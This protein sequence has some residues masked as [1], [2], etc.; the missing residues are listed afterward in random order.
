MRGNEVW[1][2]DAKATIV[3]K[4]HA[5][6]SNGRTNQMRVES[7]HRNEGV[8][9]VSNVIESA[10][11]RRWCSLILPLSKLHWSQR[12]Q[13][14]NVIAFGW[15]ST[16]FHRTHRQWKLSLCLCV[17]NRRENER[18][19]CN[20]QRG[21]SGN[22]NET[23]TLLL[24]AQQ[25]PTDNVSYI[26]RIIT[27][28]SSQIAVQCFPLC[29]SCSPSSSSTDFFLFFKCDKFHFIVFFFLC[30]F[31]CCHSMMSMCV[32]RVEVVA[33]MRKQLNSF[34]LSFRIP[35]HWRCQSGGE[36]SFVCFCQVQIKPNVTTL[37][38]IFV[39][40]VASVFSVFFCTTNF[41]C[42]L[43]NDTRFT[44]VDESNHCH[45]EVALMSTVFTDSRHKKN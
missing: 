1:Q 4:S 3:D 12:S 39:F 22:K 16:V 26:C 41:P 2:F 10:Q 5:Y 34:C 11:W 32:R 33:V 35:F 17:G 6:T 15:R 24:S 27:S 13:H 37:N 7:C 30:H 18:V 38:E 36:C 14:S 28:K 29:F 31:E 45:D 19:R 23:T 44:C 42:C 8:R 43:T 9:I 40:F 21:N 20:T 25:L